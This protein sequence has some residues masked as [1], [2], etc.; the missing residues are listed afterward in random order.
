MKRR[1]LGGEI[2]GHWKVLRYAGN[3]H[4]AC[5]CA[6]GSIKSVD[7]QDLVRGRSRSCGCSKTIF[8]QQTRA[9]FKEFSK[10]T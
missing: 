9:F 7:V 8:S 6:C 5:A 2:I 10:A 3:S 1:F 4:Y